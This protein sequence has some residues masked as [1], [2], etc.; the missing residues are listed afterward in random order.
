[1]E[2]TL[3]LVWVVLLLGAELTCLL[4]MT[5][6]PNKKLRPEGPMFFFLLGSGSSLALYSVL[7]QVV[8]LS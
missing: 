5:L 3:L 4:L 2:N 6:T 7:C 8:P 1:M